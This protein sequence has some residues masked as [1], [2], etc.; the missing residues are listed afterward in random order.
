MGIIETT[1][2]LKT[3]KS[4]LSDVGA[5]ADAVSD[6]FSNLKKVFSLKISKFKQKRNLRSA[7]L[8]N[9]HLNHQMN[10]LIFKS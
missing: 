4:T 9:N 3:L 5:G 10:L 2:G 6:K 8:K 7:N 1:D